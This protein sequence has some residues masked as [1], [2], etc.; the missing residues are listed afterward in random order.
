LALAII[1]DFK[2]ICFSLLIVEGLAISLGQFIVNGMIAEPG[3]SCLLKI[4]N[5]KVLLLLFEVAI[6]LG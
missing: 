6:A 5:G 4:A 2:I 3:R 1:E